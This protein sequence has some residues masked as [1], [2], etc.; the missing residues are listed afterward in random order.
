MS[1]D[2]QEPTCGI[3]HIPLSIGCGCNEGGKGQRGPEEVVMVGQTE[4][5]EFG[6]RYAPMVIELNRAMKDGNWVATEEIIKGMQESEGKG[7]GKVFLRVKFDARLSQPEQRDDDPF[8]HFDEMIEIDI[9]KLGKDGISLEEF[10]GLIDKLKII[11]S[12]EEVQDDETNKLISL[13]DRTS[14]GFGS[15]EDSIGL[16]SFTL[17]KREGHSE[18]Y[19]EVEM[20]GFSVETGEELVGSVKET[21]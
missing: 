7:V 20:T 9:Q 11:N 21:E 10:K 6:D 14:I 18:L 3:C 12:G 1:K 5:E 15:I 13:A 2:Y 8:E 17:S 4:I 16:S 19:S